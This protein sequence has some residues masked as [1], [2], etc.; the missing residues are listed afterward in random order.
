MAIAAFK[1]KMFNDAKELANFVVT[2]DVTTVTSIVFDASSG[3]FVIF[4]V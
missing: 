4:Y 2:G 1:M 3:K